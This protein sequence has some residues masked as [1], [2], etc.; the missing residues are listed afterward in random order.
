MGSWS[1]CG[2]DGD[3]GE[4]FRMPTERLTPGRQCGRTDFNERNMDQREQ[5]E[6]G[7]YTKCGDKNARQGGREHKADRAA[8]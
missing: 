4:A 5:M 3:G 8:W 1:G 2:G 7:I 6:V